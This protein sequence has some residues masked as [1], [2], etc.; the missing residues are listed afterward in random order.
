[1]NKTD[2]F[3]KIYTLKNPSVDSKIMFLCQLGAKLQAILVSGGCV[4]RHLE[5][6]NFF[7]DDK[8]ASIRIGFSILKLL[9]I[10][11]KTLYIP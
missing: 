5:Y 7:K 3:I 11:H 6:L 2:A 4:G 9:R 10:S 8:V 1:M